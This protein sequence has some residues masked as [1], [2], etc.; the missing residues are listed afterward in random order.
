LARS[1]WLDG[2]GRGVVGRSSASL[3]KTAEGTHGPCNL[4]NCSPI[5]E[6][7]DKNVLFANAFSEI[8]PLRY[9]IW[10]L[11]QKCI[12]GKISTTLSRVAT[13]NCCS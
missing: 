5:A 2:M 7:G 4:L 12:Y 3:W 8:A 10:L 1:Q 13:V 6:H 9:G 11:N